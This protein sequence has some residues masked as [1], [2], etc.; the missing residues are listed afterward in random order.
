MA[1]HIAAIQE[2]LRPKLPVLRWVRPEGAHLTL[3]FIGAVPAS[4]LPTIEDVLARRI[5]PFPPFQLHTARLGTFGGARARVLWLGLSG[6]LERLAALQQT[7][8]DAMAEIAIAG[9]GG[10]FSPHLTLARLPERATDE[11]RQQVRQIAAA[12]NP[13]PRLLKVSQIVLIQNQ[14]SPGGASYTNLASFPSRVS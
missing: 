12:T 4:R 9:E 2:C 1:Q 14:L 5:A 3:T 6:E 10:R 13:E 8:A 11:E 7:V